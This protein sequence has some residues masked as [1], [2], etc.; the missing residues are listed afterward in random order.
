MIINEE[1]WNEYLKNN[2]NN[3]YSEQC[4]EV[5]KKVMD[6]LDNDNS[7]LT[8]EANGFTAKNILRFF[9]SNDLTHFMA[10]VIA[11]IVIEFHHRG[12]EFKES[13]YYE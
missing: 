10:Q 13:F 7:P 2:K 6:I 3:Y 1:K 11:N 4:I 12:D 5:A 8:K 9:G